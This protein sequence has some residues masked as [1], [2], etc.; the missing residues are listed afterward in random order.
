M[1]IFDQKNLRG[2][3]YYDK[4]CYFCIYLLHGSCTSAQTWRKGKLHS[5]EFIYI[6]IVIHLGLIILLRELAD[7]LPNLDANENWLESYTLSIYN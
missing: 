5:D 1:Q 4:Q 2:L 6:H 7:E 3:I